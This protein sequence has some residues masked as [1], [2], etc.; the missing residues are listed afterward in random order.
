MKIIKN[1]Y[2]G[3]LMGKQLEFQALRFLVYQEFTSKIE[4]IFAK[5]VN[6]KR[7]RNYVHRQDFYNKQL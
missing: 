2:T 6:F 7:F 5:K 3:P 1:F 4:E